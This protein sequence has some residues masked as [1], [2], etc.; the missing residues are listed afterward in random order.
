M[1]RLILIETDIILALVSNEDKHHNEAIKLIDKFEREIVL[2]P[3]TLI[4]LDL[5]IKS[6]LIL[7]SDIKAFYS[8]LNSLLE[9]RGIKILPPKPVYHAKA[10]DLRQKYR[11]MTYFDSLHAGVGITEGIELISYDRTYVEIAELKYNHPTKHLA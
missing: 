2:S 3:Y 11:Q 5:L 4:E 1:R 6:R 10:F 8:A 7:I 9:Y